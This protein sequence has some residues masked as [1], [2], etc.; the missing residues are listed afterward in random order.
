MEI[1]SNETPKTLSPVNKAPEKKDIPTPK[2]VVKQPTVV[3]K[4]SALKRFGKLFIADTAGDIKDHVVNNVVVPSIKNCI[5]EF[6]TSSINMLFY[7]KSGKQTTNF[8][9]SW[10]TSSTNYG[11]MFSQKYSIPEAAAGPTNVTQL[12]DLYYATYDDAARVYMSLRKWIGT[13][14]CASVQTLYSLSGRTCPEDVG[15]NWGWYDLADYSIKTKYVG[16][17]LCYKLELPPVVFLNKK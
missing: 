10:I 16:G 15:Y 3:K 13:Y 7:G 2:A 4:P 9:P 12:D 14:G 8:G 1:R 17:N 11:K 5:T 6:I